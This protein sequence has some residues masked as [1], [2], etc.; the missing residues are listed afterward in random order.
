MAFKG[1]LEQKY[2]EWMVQSG[3]RQTLTAFAE[4]LGLGQSLV[5][6][7]LNGKIS[8]PSEESVHKMAKQL[9]PEIYDVLGLVRPDPQTQEL[10]TL[11]GQLA[12][13]QRDTALNLIR[14]LRQPLDASGGTSPPADIQRTPLDR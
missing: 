10:M 13:E 12:P 4:Y 14:Q 7:Y 3:K 9:G 6:Q 1:W 8:T 11:L 5:N 2:L